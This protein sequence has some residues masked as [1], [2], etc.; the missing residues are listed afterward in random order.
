MT[1]RLTRDLLELAYDLLCATAPFDG[2]NLPAGEDVV[3]KVIRSDAVRGDYSRDVQGRHVIR[4]SSRCIGTVATLIETM[5]HEMIHLH[6]GQN[7]TATRSEHN[8][9]FRKFADE[10]C[11]VHRFDAK[12]F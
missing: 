4:I 1:I 10:V 8:A 6:E 12:A 5:A 7:G 3:F 11:R 2:W 9:A